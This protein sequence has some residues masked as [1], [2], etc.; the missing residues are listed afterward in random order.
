MQELAY[1]FKEFRF[2]SSYPSTPTLPWPSRMGLRTAF[3]ILWLALLLARDQSCHAMMAKN[4][5]P[6]DRGS[7]VPEKRLRAQVVHL[8]GSNTLSAQESQEMINDL[9]RFKVQS[10]RLKHSANKAQTSSN[11]AETKSISKLSQASHCHNST[12]SRAQLL[13]PLAWRPAPVLPPS[14]RTGNE[15]SNRLLR[16]R[17]RSGHR[18]GKDS[19]C[20]ICHGMGKRMQDLA[21]LVLVAL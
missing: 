20:S 8:H 11:K 9:A 14:H 1:I 2:G 4:K 3:A 17:T 21:G 12:C 10:S 18:W 7:S 5:R 6:H 19:R 16:C 13:L 15:E